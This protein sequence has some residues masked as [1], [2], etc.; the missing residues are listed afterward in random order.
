MLF[1]SQTVIVANMP[2]PNGTIV[3]T[4]IFS[5][6]RACWRPWKWIKETARYL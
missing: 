2:K 6:R 3:P 1:A 5:I 4:W